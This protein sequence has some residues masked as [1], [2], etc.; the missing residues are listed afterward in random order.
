MMIAESQLLP[1]IDDATDGVHADLLPSDSSFGYER[2]YEK[3]ALLWSQDKPCRSVF[4]VRRGEV[5]VF[6]RGSKLQEI[7]VR[8]VKPGELC[9]LL[10]FSMGRFDAPHTT[11]RA[12]VRTM[13]TEIA[14]DDYL[15]FLKSSPDALFALLVTA[16]KRLHFAEERAHILSYRRADDRLMALLLQLVERSGRPSPSEP[17]LMR[18]H[19]THWELA[20]LSGMNR[21]HV[22]VVLGRLRRDA[23]I[24]YGRGTPMLVN[25]R[26]LLQRLQSTT[27]AGAAKS[28]SHPIKPVQI[29]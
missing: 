20:R 22:S 10:C 24:R 8:I 17:D 26:L 6:V 28:P 12:F 25:L 13:V 27:K 29:S 9:G 21:P 1:G 16:C 7:P 14:F 5:E 2:T 3:G 4:I 18:I 15:K 19:Y 11:A 23:V